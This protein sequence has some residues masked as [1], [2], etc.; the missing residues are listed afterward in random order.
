M[1]GI[2]LAVVPV[3]ASQTAGTIKGQLTDLK[4][5]RVMSGSP[6][7]GKKQKKHKGPKLD[8]SKGHPSPTSSPSTTPPRNL[9]DKATLTVDGKEFE[10][11]AEDLKEL[12][13]LGH[14]AYGFVYKMIHEPT[15]NIMAVKR[16]RANVNST[17]QKR[18]L[19]DLDV[20]M[21]VSD[22]PYTVHFYGALFREGDVW[23]CMELMKAS[24][25]KLYRKVYATPDGR[26]PEEVLRQI[27][28]AMVN[29][30]NYLHD[31]LKVIHRDVK[32]SNIL[33]DEN[34]NF[35]LCDFGISGQLVDS[36]AKTVDAGCK[37]YMAPERIN[38]ARDMKG[39]DIRSDIWSLGITMIE[40]ATGKFPYTQWKTPFEQLKQ[41]VH[42]P[43]PT[44][45]DD[46]P[47]SD[48]FRDFVVQCLK[49]DYKERP[50]YVSL[51]EHEFLKENNTESSFDTKQ[52][53]MPILQEMEQSS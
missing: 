17:E 18:L 4:E 8:F 41:V 16:I 28:F 36:L 48:E 39:Y 21:R 29:A 25:D 44:L 49:K 43:S 37:P 40:L 24:L 31:K 46:G 20:S 38:P 5:V 6:K 52:W 53:I 13:E 14:G 15:G 23:I 10:C 7:T 45:P 12:K 11:N 26:V 50:N 9:S 22:C 33:V 35:K 34:G 51:L 19:M 1:G 3:K 27:A 2:P 42:E 47:Y 30:L 32:P